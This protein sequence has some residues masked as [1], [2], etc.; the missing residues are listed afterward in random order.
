MRF[1]DQPVTGA[2][3]LKNL[4]EAEKPGT[5]VNLTTFRK[6][7]FS[8]VSA[9]LGERPLA[10]FYE[11]MMKYNP[12]NG[13]DYVLFPPTR[14][15]NDLNYYLFQGKIYS[16][17]N[18]VIIVESQ[19]KNYNYGRYWSF[20]MPPQS[21]FAPRVKTEVMV[22]GKIINVLDG[23]TVLRKPLHMVR[24]RPVAIADASGRL[25]TW[26]QP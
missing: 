20:D 24:V 6:G 26:S 25:L 9:K 11:A 15:P 12:R 17:Q 21:S 19:S 3:Q 14:K 18:S 10:D 22:I 13:M 7:E 16:G 2:A 8:N 23:E 4:I 5:Q 1:N